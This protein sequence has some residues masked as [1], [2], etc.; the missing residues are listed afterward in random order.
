LEYLRNRKEQVKQDTMTPQDA[1]G[2][3]S[4]N[5]NQQAQ[6]AGVDMNNMNQVINM[7]NPRRTL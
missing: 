6:K 7:M 2:R 1:V 4:Q 3:L 5:F